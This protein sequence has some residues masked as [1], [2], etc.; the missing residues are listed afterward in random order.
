MALHL[1]TG[2]Q[3]QGRQAM[4]TRVARHLLR[5]DKSGGNIRKIPGKGGG[6]GGGPGHLPFANSALLIL[7]SIW[8]GP[9]ANNQSK[10]FRGQHPSPYLHRW[11]PTSFTMCENKYLIIYKS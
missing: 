10:T 8:W 11:M 7:M 9:N 1:I 4:A 2:P 3:G 5:W 6:G